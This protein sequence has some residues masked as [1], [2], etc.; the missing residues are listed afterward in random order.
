MLL[1]SEGS[2]GGGW[3]VGVGSLGVVL[4]LGQ[5][6]ISGHLVRVVWIVL[7]FLFVVPVKLFCGSQVLAP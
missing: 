1:G 2:V 6:A 3:L 5:A 7:P 4:L